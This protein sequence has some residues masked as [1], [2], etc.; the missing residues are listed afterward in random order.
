VVSTINNTMPGSSAAPTSAFDASAGGQSPGTFAAMCALQGSAPT[1]GSVSSSGIAANTNS[2]P[3]VV[4]KT[5]ASGTP[6]S[7]DTRK[8]LPADPANAALLAFLVSVPPI[9]PENGPLATLGCS[10]TDPSPKA[11]DVVASAGGPAEAAAVTAKEPSSADLMSALKTTADNN[12]AGIPPPPSD[13]PPPISLLNPLPPLGATVVQAGT[14]AGM[15]VTPDFALP[16]SD[17]SDTNALG[18]Q[19]PPC[20]S[21]HA[22]PQ[23]SPLSGTTTP[24]NPSSHALGDLPAHPPDSRMV[25]A[26]LGEPPAN[27]SQ[28]LART[29]FAN[30]FVPPVDSASNAPMVATPLENNSES[31]DTTA[32]HSSGQGLAAQ[33]IADLVD[34]SG[35]IQQPFGQ[36]GLTGVYMRQNP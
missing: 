18:L 7:K 28:T 21:T 25:D 33:A 3:A 35:R 4:G 20:V 34:D 12:T 1:E 17:Q 5:V 13:L 2:S 32:P 36:A 11:T 24:Q 23:G 29:A 30:L 19:P 26:Q 27:T 14:A 15:S 9:A 8:P 31:P 6:N 10:S 16:S 22:S